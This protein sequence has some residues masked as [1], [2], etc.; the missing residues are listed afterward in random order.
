MALW[1]VITLVTHFGQWLQP[2]S[3]SP[4]LV[5][6]I[7]IRRALV[8]SVSCFRTQGPSSL[9]W[10][11]F[12]SPAHCL[13]HGRYSIKVSSGNEWIKGS[14][15][16][17]TIEP[18]RLSRQKLKCIAIIRRSCLFWWMYGIFFIAS[19]IF[20]LF[21]PPRNIKNLKSVRFLPQDREDTFHLIW[22]TCISKKKFSLYFQ[23]EGRFSFL[24]SSTVEDRCYS[25]FHLSLSFISLPFQELSFSIFS[26]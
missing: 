26:K 8:T 25:I 14:L 4:F 12:Q 3:I 17:W 16:W 1:I 24:I 15:Y 11:L 23:K 20:L 10:H 2:L 5:P 7:P 13:P 19:F 18:N 22:T 21:F 6:W 9:P